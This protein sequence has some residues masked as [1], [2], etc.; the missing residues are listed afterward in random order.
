MLFSKCLHQRTSSPTL[1][2]KHSFW[3][4]RTWILQFEFSSFYWLFF[5]VTFRDSKTLTLGQMNMPTLQTRAFIEG[6]TVTKSAVILWLKGS[7]ILSSQIPRPELTQQIFSDCLLYFRYFVLSTSKIEHTVWDTIP[8]LSPVMLT[9]E[10]QGQ[11][12][13]LQEQ[14]HTELAVFVEFTRSRHFSTFSWN[15]SLLVCQYWFLV[16]RVYKIIV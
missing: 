2:G 15:N 14:R 10:V 12:I 4:D 3:L 11:L 13:N 16:Y 8:I 6:G 9:S 5:I 7:L 1:R